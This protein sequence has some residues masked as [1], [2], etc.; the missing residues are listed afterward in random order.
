MRRLG[1]DSAQLSTLKL[2]ADSSNKVW[3]AFYATS[4]P[5]LCSSSII[6]HSPV[7]SAPHC[8]TSLEL[9]GRYLSIKIYCVRGEGS[10][11]VC[12]LW[13]CFFCSGSYF[14]LYW[15]TLLLLLLFSEEPGSLPDWGHFSFILGGGCA[16]VGAGGRPFDSFAL[17]FSWKQKLQAISHPV[18]LKWRAVNFPVSQVGGGTSLLCVWNPSVIRFNV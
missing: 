9:P 8:M 14:S 10:S 4:S 7:L 11:C 16:A 15:R 3:A 17:C 5:F 1:E 12:H 6:T 2:S 18:N 13:L